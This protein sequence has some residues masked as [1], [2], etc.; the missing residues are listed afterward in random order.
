MVNRN[1]HFSKIHNYLELIFGLDSAYDMTTTEQ[2]IQ[3]R[4]AIEL[5]KS[6]NLLELY[7]EVEKLPIMT[8]TQIGDGWEE[9]NKLVFR[10][11]KAFGID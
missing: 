1:M 6:A 10:L 11:R 5:L 2:A 8:G 9:Y 4:N 7:R 3:K